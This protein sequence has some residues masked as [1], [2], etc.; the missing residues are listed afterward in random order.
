MH[1]LVETLRPYGRGWLETLEKLGE[2]E[3]AELKAF[4]SN[5]ASN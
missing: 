3:L 1:T 5:K 4:R 2:T